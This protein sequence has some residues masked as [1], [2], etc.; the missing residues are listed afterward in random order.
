[1]SQ[2]A[3]SVPTVIV[4]VL[5]HKVYL[6]SLSQSF[7]TKCTSRHCHSPLAQSVPGCS[8]G[9]VLL[10]V[11]VKGGC[12]EGGLRF[13]S[14]SGGV[15]SPFAQSGPTVI[16]TVGTKCT[17]RHCHSPLTQSVPTVIVTVLWHKVYGV[18]L[19][20]GCML[21]LKGGVVVFVLSLAVL[22]C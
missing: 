6:P 1:M 10:Y 19:K 9:G 4:T 3:Q 21:L 20:G 15:A 8:S 5:W 12:C 16:V 14:S 13:N 7:D 11:V 2:S 22:L 17:Y 18:V